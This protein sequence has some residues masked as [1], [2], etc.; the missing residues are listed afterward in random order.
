MNQLWNRCLHQKN[1]GDGNK[2]CNKLY[3]PKL[4]I[5]A[6][7]LTATMTGNS[8]FALIEEDVNAPNSV[9]AP[10]VFADRVN[11]NQRIDTKSLNITEFGGTTYTQL[12]VKNKR[13]STT[14]K[15]G[16]IQTGYIKAD[17]IQAGTLIATDG[18]TTKS[19]FVTE[20][21]T[22]SGA[23]LKNID[24]G[25]T[26]INHVIDA[27]RD[28]Q[29]VNFKQLKEQDAQTL[30][31]AKIYIDDTTTTLRA[32]V[33]A[34]TERL[35]QEIA[36][37]TNGDAQTLAD[38]KAYTDN[39]A[40]TLR[41]E[42]AT[43]SARLDKAIV[44]GNTSTLANAKT[45]T[46]NTA[47]TLRSEAV[48][49]SARLDKAIADG[50]ASTLASAN[51]TTADMAI[52]IRNEV[53]DTNAKTL[54][55]AKAHTNSIAVTTLNNAKQYTDQSS[56]SVLEQ[57]KAYTDANANGSPFVALQ[58]NDGDELAK[59]EGTRSIAIGVGAVAQGEQSIAIGVGNQVTGNHSGAIGDPNVVSGNASYAVG[60]NNTVNGDNTFVFGND[61]NT[62]ATNAVVLGNTSTSDRD[63]TVSVG[64]VGGE[65][66]VIH[67]AAATADTDA[68]N[69]KQMK[70]ADTA[71][72]VSAKMHTDN[73]ATTLR[74]EAAVESTRV[75]EAIVDG[76]KAT[77]VSA[78]GYTDVRV[79]TFDRSINQ[80]NN[81][82]NQLNTRVDD[83]E[84]TAYRGIAIALAAQQAVPSI[85]PGQVAVFGGVG[86]YE[87]ET[88]GSI[89]VVTSFTNRISASGALG[90][91]GGD[92][93]GGRVGVAYVFGGK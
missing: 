42:A 78:K 60:N 9:Q 74:N 43:E 59:A 16:Y 77:L 18:L 91:A 32:E 86:H 71:T 33:T 20:K 30:A 79:A 19:L 13:F 55:D 84:R 40:T 45:Y 67:V 31:D 15:E 38:A 72:L 24:A 58:S 73:T 34:E 57:A 65:R 50:N 41:S 26:N 81:R 56:S 68:V 21:L 17:E 3:V 14:E 22:A 62:N 8:A 1:C 44:D 64:S 48:T 4:S 51:K 87:G 53:K 63:N 66:Q 54:A 61:I 28:D 11:A 82:V 27:V 69:L 52:A 2:E 37:V 12:G 92:E 88:A 23:S 7:V 39:T 5:L 29:A 75:N 49:E 85:Q 25:S 93:F 89:G 35:D 90:F 36:K 6:V 46:D 83:V 80:L 47:T 10:N 70:M 76:D